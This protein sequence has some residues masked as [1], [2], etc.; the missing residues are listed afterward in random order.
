M[1]PFHKTQTLEE[2]G[3]FRGFIDWHSHILPGV[4]DGVQTME[5][6]LRIL[7]AYERLGIKEVW[8]TPHIMEDVP[9]T[10][11]RLRERFTKLQAAY[12]G[13]VTLHLS[14]ENMLDKLFEERLEQNDLLPIGMEGKHLL[15]ETSYFNPPM[16]LQDILLRIK[17]KGYYP[18][19]AHPERYLYM[20]D[21]DYRLLKS[22]DVRFQL[23]LL[24]LAGAYG[25]DVRKKAQTLLKKGMYDC[26]GTDIHRYDRLE[27]LMDVRIKGNL[28]HLQFSNLQFTILLNGNLARASA[29]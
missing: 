7:A 9:N 14:A 10:T 26:A 2:S 15:V 20:E 24:S 3:F 6:A 5:E 12:Q 22:M 28:V 1:W 27:M 13:N 8:L 23:N 17:A 4:D 25:K 18:V 11:A 21:K 19:L 29:L 16:G